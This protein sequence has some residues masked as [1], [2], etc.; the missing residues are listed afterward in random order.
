MG[1]RLGM[2]PPQPGDE[3]PAGDEAAKDESAPAE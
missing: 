2:L 3:P 1:L